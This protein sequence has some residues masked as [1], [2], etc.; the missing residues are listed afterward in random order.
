MSMSYLT[1]A[2]TAWHGHDFEWRFR[3][4]GISKE[5]PDLSIRVTHALMVSI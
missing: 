5:G 1:A 2:H 3:P 4:S